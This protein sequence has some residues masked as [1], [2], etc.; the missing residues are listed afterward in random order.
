MV[1]DTGLTRLL[2]VEKDGNLAERCIILGTLRI[3][4]LHGPKTGKRVSTG[5][6]R[7]TE[8][9]ETISQEMKFA[10]FAFTPGKSLDFKYYSQT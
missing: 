2:A 3:F 9:R 8:D 5:S 6:A 1:D 10:Y 4:F 7:K